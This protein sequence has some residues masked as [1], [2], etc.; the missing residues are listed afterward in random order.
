[1]SEA[2]AEYETAVAG[3]REAGDTRAAAAAM[4][5]LSDALETLGDPR[6]R[7]VFAAAVELAEID[8]PSPVMVDVLLGQAAAVHEDEGPPEALEVIERAVAMAESLGMPMPVGALVLRG[9]ARCT[10]GDA[11]G[12]Q[13]LRRAIEAAERD[14]RRVDQAGLLAELAWCLVS[15]EGPSAS[16]QALEASRELSRR[17]RMEG[18]VVSARSMAVRSLY[19]AGEW[20][21]ALA[22]CRDLVPILE[23]WGDAWGLAIVRYVWS[24]LLLGRGDAVGAEPLSALALEVA[25]DNPIRG[26]SAVYL[27]AAAAARQGVG[28]DDAA[29]ALLEE[30]R[31]ALRGKGD[32]VF[33]YL[34]PL[35]VRTATAAGD[36]GLAR[37]L[38]DV[39]VPVLPFSEH[40][41]ATLR[42]QVLE[43]DGEV[44]EAAAAFA[45]AAA[46][47]HDFGIPYEE[48]QALLGQGR[49]LVALGRAPEPAAPLAAAREIFER[50]GA[51]P[52]LV[53]TDALLQEALAHAG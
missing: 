23:E 52:A 33:V 24:L 3:L 49:C 38:A 13:D 36:A 18:L 16:L 10:L 5:G 42:A 37:S 19:W 17:S 40:V 53:E 48:A 8:A 29:C 41:D 32:T 15:F 46:R 43:I 22:E 50:L 39:V 4:N 45:A 26:V 28:D 34:L 11:G 2:A 27:V 1:L 44:A 47:W 31:E 51:K 25:R 9:R 35:A 7:E 30:C 14:G 20:D 12:L 21:T 6:Y